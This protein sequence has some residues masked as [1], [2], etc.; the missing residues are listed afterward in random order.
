MDPLQPMSLDRSEALALLRA[1]PV[2]AARPAAAPDLV[3]AF[4]LAAAVLVSIRRPLLLR[5]VGRTRTQVPA[6]DALGEDLTPIKARALDGGWMLSAEARRRALTGLTPDAA[7]RALRVNPDERQGWLQ[8]VYEGLLLGAEAEIDGL[9]RGQLEQLLQVL[10]WLVDVRPIEALLQRTRDRLEYLRYMAPFESLAGDDVFHGRT[11]EMDELRRHVGVLPPAQ[12]TARLKTLVEAT[13]GHEDTQPA[14]TLYGAGGIGKSTLI[15]R[16]ALEHLRLAESVRIPL[17]YLDF[18]RADRDIGDPEGLVIEMVRQIR[19][20]RPET[21][22]FDQLWSFCQKRSLHEAASRGEPSLANDESRS[23]TARAVSILADLL[24]LLRQCKAPQ[25]LVLVLDSFEEVQYRNEARAFRLWEV[26]QQMG[27]GHR[28]LRVVISGRAPVHSLHLNNERPKELSVRELDVAAARSFL[29]AK[30]VVDAQADS[31]IRLV[32]GS[33]LSL[34]LAAT[35]LE[36]SSD[37]DTPLKGIAGKR[38]LWLSA[39]DEVIQGQLYDRI[40]GHIHSERVRAL[41]HPGL[42]LR[43]VT[44]DVILH[45]LNGPCQLELTN[46]EEAEELFAE[47]QR[48]TSLVSSDDTDGAL[49]HRNDLRRI[50]LRLIAIKDPNKA[51]QIHRAAVHFYSR[52]RGQRERAEEFYHRLHLGEYPERVW[53][54][55]PE[56]RASIQASIADLPESAQRRLLS[57]GFMVDSDVLKMAEAEDQESAFIS[58]AERRLQFGRTALMQTRDE[59]YQRIKDEGTS[60]K[61]C[62]L[63]AR[64]T[65]QLEE[66]AAR[67]DWLDRARHQLLASGDTATMLE[68]FSER[69]WDLRDAGDGDDLREALDGLREHASRL[70]QKWALAQHALQF[71]KWATHGNAGRSLAVAYAQAATAIQSIDG[72]DL[73]AIFPLAAEEILHFPDSLEPLWQHLFEL[74][75]DAQGP[76]AQAQ[77]D[78]SDCQDLLEALILI[79]RRGADSVLAGQFGAQAQ[80]QMQMLRAAWPYQV[81]RVQPPY[82]SRSRSLRESA[83]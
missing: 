38:R 74:I 58:T 39:S 43:R 53:F 55:D 28:H 15:G 61:L 35:L 47:L 16:F 44:P 29:R 32:G 26:L 22:I 40:L 24:G 41:A 60:L 7:A 9:E 6:P 11:S 63:A 81:L 65:G 72:N 25:P 69:C 1:H 45:V 80:R 33:P 5:P 12:L 30:G 19:V 20:Q 49:V 10:L 42:V 50:M 17:A 67:A 37:E 73:W 51:E 66:Q 83:A 21:K 18:D 82:G 3:D 13:L 23:G 57:F 56:V 4:R 48:E 31:I 14:L 34:L 27:A 8:H 79:S 64:V 70:D 77:F 36:R 76:F 71:I 54:L 62:L 46:K 68:Y 78:D 75:G 52:R 59:I 2:A